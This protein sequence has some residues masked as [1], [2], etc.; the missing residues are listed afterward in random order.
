MSRVSCRSFLLVAVACTLAPGAIAQTATPPAAPTIFEVATIKPIDPTPGVMH[1]VGVKVFPGGRVTIT[2]FSLKSLICTAFDIDYWQLSGGDAWTEKERYDLEAK[3][4]QTDPPVTYNVRHSNGT[5]ADQRLRKMLQ[6]LLIE[7]FQLKFHRDTTTGQVYLL[8]KSGKAI[9]L[10]LS[11]ESAAKM[12][13]EG[14]SGEVGIA[15]NRWGIYNAS[16]RDVA[17]YFSNSF[18][19]RPVLDHTGIDGAFD[20]RWTIPDTEPNVRGEDFMNMVQT[21]YPLFVDAMG[22]K[23]TKSTGPVEAFVIDHAEPPSPN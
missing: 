21:S 1:M 17:K 19:H 12:Y 15:G 16:M 22:L 4:A 7:R 9:P 13:G 8:E 5:I 3:P 10:V 20:F 14:Y 18:L 11:K 6:A 23:L 2:T